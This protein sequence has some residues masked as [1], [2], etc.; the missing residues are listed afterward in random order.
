M[1]STISMFVLITQFVLVACHQYGLDKFAKPH[2][3]KRPHFNSIISHDFDYTL[4]GKTY[5]GYVSYPE[6]NI[7][8]NELPGV[9]IGHQWMG[10]GQMEKFRADEMASYGYVSFA[11]DVYGKGIRPKTPEEA[12]G[13]VTEL[14][15]HP[16]EFHKRVNKGLEIL[17]SLGEGPVVNKSALVANGYCFGGL[18]VLELARLGTSLVGVASF[19]GDLGALQDPSQDKIKAAIQVHHADLDSQG[20]DGLLKFENEMRNNG[21]QTWATTKYGNCQ[22]GWTDPFSSIYE[23]QAAKQSHASMRHFYSYLLGHTENI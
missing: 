14:K 10:L 23:E 12:R 2:N 15:S 5:E 9:L 19:H 18:M 8:D 4:D 6:Q 20:D 13:N 3:W 16:A 22:H 17:M 1:V 21:V 7:F 11:L